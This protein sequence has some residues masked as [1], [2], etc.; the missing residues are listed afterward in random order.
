MYTRIMQKDV[1]ELTGFSYKKIKR[2]VEFNHIKF[3]GEF[4]FKDSIL[5]YI[6]YEK[7]IRN[8]YYSLKEFNEVAHL[9]KSYIDLSH[10]RETYPNFYTVLKVLKTKVSIDYNTIFIEKV[11]AHKFKELLNNSEPERKKQ[12]YNQKE[13]RDITNWSHKRIKYYEQ[14][15][16]LTPHVGYKKML[17]YP[18]EEVKSIINEE[19]CII[20]NYY[21]FSEAQKILGLH[22]GSRSTIMNLVNHGDLDYFETDISIDGFSKTWISKCSLHNFLK[23]ID[24]EYID[25]ETIAKRLGINNSYTYKLFSIEEKFQY[26]NKVFVSKEVAAKYISLSKEYY[27][28][29]EIGNLFNREVN[30]LR[31]LVHKEEFTNLF[32]NCRELN[33]KWNSWSFEKSEVDNYLKK[34]EDIKENFFTR[35]ELLKYLDLKLLPPYNPINKIETPKYMRILSPTYSRFLYERADAKRYKENLGF[36]A[37]L[38]SN[39]FSVN[40]ELFKELVESKVFPCHLEDTKKFFLSYADYAFSLSKSKNQ[41]PTLREL[42]NLVNYLLKDK[43]N[44]ELYLLKD[45]EFANIM[46]TCPTKKTQ[47]MLWNIARFIEERRITL[48]NTSQHLSPFSKKYI[49]EKKKEVL[50]LQQLIEIYKHCQSKEHIKR[51]IEN[52]HYASMWLFTMILLTNAWRPSDVFRIPPISPEAIGISTI[53]ELNFKQITLPQAQKIINIIHSLKLVTAKNG[54][55]RNFTCNPDM[56]PHMVTAMCICEFHRRASRN[57]STLIDLTTDNKKKNSIRSEDFAKFL[58]TNENTK[59]IKF[60]A[61]I[62]NRSILE[63]LFYSIQEKKGEGNSAF[64][65]VMKFRAHKTDIT[66]EYIRNNNMEVVKHMFWR[67]EFGYVYDRLISLFTN[68]QQ[69]LTRRTENIKVLKTFFTPGELENS[70]KFYSLICSEEEETFLETLLNTSPS[71]AFE[72][73]RAIYLGQFPSKSPNIQCLIYPDCHRISNKYKCE[74]CPFAVHNVYALQSLFI[75]FR[76]SLS[77]YN[78]TNKIGAKIREKHKL[79]KIQDALSYAI[80]KFGEDYVFSFLPGGEKRFIKMLGGE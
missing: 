4:Y 54:M 64:E 25:T 22:K 61:L 59:D 26:K 70:A 38:D 50:N 37:L 39:R 71:E 29:H 45:A 17:L 62:A 79:F 65:V 48:Y 53:D 58:Q 14:V 44:K 18:I 75:E 51:A 21:P 6:E 9:A 43:L 35:N 8:E 78:T 74:T 34:I 55:I 7:K 63:N 28:L 31:E 3:D 41:I 15:K 10:I 27:S 52:S 42:I 68:E 33:D 40:S 47:E 16:V 32:T 77:I 11:S 69:S 24:E 5:E 57:I 49:K 36:R 72:K 60:N 46:S 13:L 73:V 76:E 23:K 1:L 80:G 67:G 66:Q 20:R 30:N 56:A 2:L 12:F 19:E